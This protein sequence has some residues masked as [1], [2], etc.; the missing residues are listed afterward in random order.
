MQK[1]I[2]GLASTLFIILLSSCASMPKMGSKRYKKL[3]LSVEATPC[4]G[5]CPIY[6]FELNGENKAT[7]SKVRFIN[8]KDEIDYRA[9]LNKE[10]AFELFALA[11][12]QGWDTLKKDY[13]SGYA[14]LPGRIIRYS[15]A[16]GDTATVFFEFGNAPIFLEKIA[17]SADSIRKSTIWAPLNVVYE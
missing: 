2:T 8:L 11:H 4:F 3:Y 9:D 6:T 5:S 14:D 17:R 1:I 13:R 16:V 15:S 12:K 10:N 7:L